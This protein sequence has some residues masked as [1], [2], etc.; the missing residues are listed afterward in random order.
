M[1]KWP[2]MMLALS[3]LASATLFAQGSRKTIE[4][5]EFT[6]IGLGLPVAVHVMKG[7]NKVEVEGPAEAVEKMKFETR[8]GSLNIERE[9]KLK[10]WKG[11]GVTVYVTMPNISGLA[12]GGSGDIIVKDEFSEMGD[13]DLS[14]GGSGNIEISGKAKQVSISIAGSGDVKASGLSGGSCNVSIA[15][16]GNANVGEMKALEVSIAGSGDVGYKGD[17]KV[18]KSIAGSGDVKKM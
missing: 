18:S 5:G 4:T 14:I 15:G 17:P 2:I 1:K 8:G 12:I 16:S 3:L 6:S 10:S 7:A 13:L 9:E 11:N